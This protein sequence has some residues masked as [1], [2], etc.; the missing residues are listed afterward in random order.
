MS[1]RQISRDTQPR[2]A[3]VNRFRFLRS[4]RSDSEWSWAP[5]LGRYHGLVDTIVQ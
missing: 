4:S 1:F 3:R 2:R 5:T